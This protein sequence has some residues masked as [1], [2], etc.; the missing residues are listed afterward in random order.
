MFQNEKKWGRKKKEI[1]DDHILRI[2]AHVKDGYS[3]RFAVAKVM[4]TA[5]EAYIKRIKEQYPEMERF[6]AESKKR[7]LAFKPRPGT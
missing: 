4:G 2:I 3:F 1:T 7:S 5:N 6:F